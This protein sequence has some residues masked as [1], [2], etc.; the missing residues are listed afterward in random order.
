MSNARGEYPG[1]EASRMGGA[2]TFLGRLTFRPGLMRARGS[3]D[4]LME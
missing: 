3:I 1:D 4:W 2:R